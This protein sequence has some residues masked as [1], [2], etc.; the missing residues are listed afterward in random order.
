MR[1]R[2]K[3]DGFKDFEVFKRIDPP[4]SFDRDNAGNWSP[5][6][7]AC[8]PPN[9]RRSDY[10]YP[11]VLCGTAPRE[12]AEII[13]AARQRPVSKKGTDLLHDLAVSQ[14][15]WKAAVWLMKDLIDHFGPAVQQAG[16]P[17]VSQTLWNAQVSLHQITSE[18]INLPHPGRS[19]AG[20]PL[21]VNLP[22]MIPLDI[23]EAQSESEDTYKPDSFARNVL[24][25]VW[26]T[27][28]AMIVSCG[29]GPVRPEILEIIAHLHHQDLLPKDIYS[30][31]PGED[32][33]AI[34]QPPT[35]HLLSSRI[36]TSLSDA[37]WRA[38]E[39]VIVDKASAT[40][41]KYIPLRPEI[42]GTAYRIHIAGLR[43]EVWLELVLWACLHGHWVL[44]GAAILRSICGQS[45]PTWRPISWRLLMP[46][47]SGRF[48]DWHKLEYIFNTR[49]PKTMDQEAAVHDVKRTVSSEV[50]NAY[51]D[52]L[53]SEMNAGDADRA[54]R[55]VHVLQDLMV[56][57][58][59][60]ERSDVKLGR[61]SW[62]AVVLRFVEAA[63][64][65][66]KHSNYLRHLIGLGGEVRS[67]N[68]RDMPPYVLDGSAAM[69]G[70]AHQALRIHI[71][72]G[73]L[74][75][76][77]QVLA[78]L[79]IYADANKKR[80]SGDSFASP[81]SGTKPK[82][83][84]LFTS[85][86]DTRNDPALELKL[87]STIL[88][89][90]LELVTD[91]AQT[92]TFGKRLLYSEEGNDPLIPES[93]YNDPAIAPA[94]VRFAV[95]TNDRSLLSKLVQTRAQ[96]D[97]ETGER[98]ELP[99]NVLQAFL[100]AQIQL[101]EWAAA[102]RILQT[103]AETKASG[104][105]I[106]NLAVLS[107]TMILLGKPNQSGNEGS[108]GNL[109]EA[110]SLFAAMVKGEYS[111]PR[112]NNASMREQVSSLLT[113]ISMTDAQWT[114]FCPSVKGY[115]R[116]FTFNLPTRAFNKVLEGVLDTYGVTAAHRLLMEFWPLSLR[117]A[118]TR[119]L[120]ERTGSSNS[121]YRRQSPL[122][123]VQRHRSVVQLPG[124]DGREDSSVVV[125]AGPQPDVI[126]IRMMFRQAL[127]RLKK[128]AASES[129]SSS[130]S[131]GETDAAST[132]SPP[133]SE[134][135]LATPVRIA[136]WCIRR[137][138]DLGVTETDISQELEEAI[139]D[140]KSED[141][142]G[143]VPRLFGTAEE[144]RTGTAAR[145]TSRT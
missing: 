91:D 124:R 58:D 45:E 68:T 7:E 97:V 8:L 92:Y 33:T 120:A 103:L 134:T 81:Q 141:L 121:L 24:G 127:E 69:V 50:V 135:R 21:H 85:N 48:E 72:A 47:P 115:R 110:K 104:W 17:T 84:G 11:T 139:P 87:P 67:I 86:F 5:L 107:R 3:D 41:S 13:L 111:G 75:P 114:S 16:Q 132:G 118:Q 76:A 51:V 90:Y 100:D 55:P 26:R 25:V 63:G 106:V 60:L 4:P 39:Q 138:I 143:V 27:L 23:A 112:H 31:T 36:L 71:K 102:R 108:G 53:L 93:L 145:T 130:D 128:D 34:Q 96:E 35:L 123:L 94:L 61:G 6:L 144:Y 125:Y 116:W 19:A 30:R 89:P 66:A 64:D 38:H 119:Q 52:A 95:A 32:E 98:Q 117:L 18:P 62:D 49:S 136:Q 140:R 14:G 56:L 12:R 78:I 59:F 28:G 57:H 131:T 137:L 20:S 129:T 113:V 73:N 9:L 122:D 133:V 99:Q 65:I 1:G 88:G 22:Q 77:L 109:A 40:G 42:P 126:T 82:R 29:D 142:Q 46:V 74:H 37:A 83:H 15:R 80:I 101:H 79:R 10:G 54:V 2:L 43:T 44:E 105:N 70:I